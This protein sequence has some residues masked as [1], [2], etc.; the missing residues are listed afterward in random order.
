MIKLL[1]PHTRVGL[2]TFG[3]CVSVY[4][5]ASEGLVAADV[6][7]ATGPLPHPLVQRL[8]QGARPHLGSLGGS[9]A[10]LQR[11]LESFRSVCAPCRGAPIARAL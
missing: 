6:L 5:L 11:A 10:S 7:P 2:L 3:S 9:A 8:H 1:P 4:R